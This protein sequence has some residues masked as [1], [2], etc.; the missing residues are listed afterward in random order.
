MNIG[1]LFKLILRLA[2]HLRVDD[3]AAYSSLTPFEAEYKR[4]AWWTICRYRSAY[5]EDFSHIDIPNKYAEVALPSNYNDSDLEPGMITCPTPREELSE[6]SIVLM[7]L[8]VVK[9]L[10]RLEATKQPQNDGVQATKSGVQHLILATKTEVEQEILTKCD[11]SRPFDW[12][13]LLAGQVI[14]VSSVRF[15]MRDCR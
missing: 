14:L 12:L 9:L 11:G 8:K 6:L 3:L 2:H 15:L 10:L 4:R 5:A 7:Q 13:I 1:A